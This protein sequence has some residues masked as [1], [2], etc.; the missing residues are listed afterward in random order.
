M[1]TCACVPLALFTHACRCKCETQREKRGQNEKVFH[2]SFLGLV[3]VAKLLIY[4]CDAIPITETFKF[5]KSY[6]K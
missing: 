3:D 4:F 6:R 5:K 2:F 1:N